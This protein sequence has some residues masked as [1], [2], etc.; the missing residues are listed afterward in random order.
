MSLEDPSD[1]EELATRVVAEG[2]SV[3]G[4]EEAVVL[5][6]GRTVK[7]KR[8]APKKLVMP[9]LT[10]LAGTLSDTFDTRVRV[11]LG[12]QKGRVIVEFATV[13]DL[14]RI[15]GIMAPAALANRR[16]GVGPKETA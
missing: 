2:L 8:S 11:E 12:R 6:A 15:I 4:T 10:A 9:S 1:Q 3:R 13:D 14:E 16:N 7:G 5:M